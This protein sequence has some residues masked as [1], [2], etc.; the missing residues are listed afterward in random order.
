MES[1]KVEKDWY[2]AQYNA[3]LSEE[4][5]KRNRLEG[6]L[7]AKLYA[8]GAQ[9]SSAGLQ[10]MALQVNAADMRLQ[11]KQSEYNYGI[12]KLNL[13]SRNIMNNYTNNVV[14]LN[15]DAQDKKTVANEKYDEKLLQIEGLLIQDNKEKNKLRFDAFAQF[16][17]AMYKI[18]QDKKTREWDEYKQHY[19][20]LQD[21]ID[22][23][24]KLNGET[25]T[26]HY[27]DKDGEIVDSGV[28]TFAYDQW[29]QTN[30]LDWAKYN[31]N[32]ESNTWAKA[33]DMLEGGVNP[34]FVEQ[35]TGMKV[36]S[37]SGYKSTLERQ[38]A[39]EKYK[40]NLE[41]SF[42]DMPYIS[43]VGDVIA[44]M[45]SDDDWGG[46][47]GEFIHNFVTDYP[48]GL[49]TLDQKM[50]TIN[51]NT[52]S[53]GS[54]VILDES[55]PGTN[56]GHVAMVNAIANGKLRLTESNYVG[57]EIVS[58]DREIDINYP[59]I[60]GYFNGTLKP[61]IKDSIAKMNTID[62]SVL[63]KYNQAFNNVLVKVG[64]VKSKELKQNYNYYMKS[65][66]ME[67]AKNYLKQIGMEYNLTG[68]QKDDYDDFTLVAQGM[69]RIA[70]QTDPNSPSGIYTKLFNDARKWINLEQDEKYR[71]L[72][73]DVFQVQAA[74]KRALYGTAVTSTEFADGQKFL[75]RDD[76]KVKD[77][78]FK[79]KNMA[80]Y[81]KQVTQNI[82]SRALGGI[83]LDSPVEG[84]T[85]NIYNKI[86]DRAKKLKAEKAKYDWNMVEVP[87]SPEDILLQF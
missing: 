64:P 12:S 72:F 16:N 40:N 78:I 30:Y 70:K 82:E 50:T 87:N 1:V 56:T 23:A 17:T 54:V 37:L 67:A 76:D 25:G 34:A 60:K 31:H 11:L 7:K 9:D 84:Q 24:F 5:D 26:V 35:L 61:G 48:T 55:Y 4:T 69:E 74:Y 36:G 29:E 14:K 39:L 28:K 46:Q 41:N 65:G 3:W 75:I 81:A 44:T 2:T 8:A 77:I 32:V 57:K 58:N 10:T 33:K 51:S 21:T 86:I 6:Y 42:V 59:K 15:M 47:C 73:A 71:D 62:G 18:D 63:N 38:E 27:V 80:S 45:Y 66:D 49:N 85:K 22:N 83:V 43:D 68:K 53:V 19:K 79:A 52:P 13:E 20:E